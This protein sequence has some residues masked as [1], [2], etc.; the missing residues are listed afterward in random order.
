M[1]RNGHPDLK[2]SIPMPEIAARRAPQMDAGMRPIAEATK[3]ITLRAAIERI[4]RKAEI[5]AR[6]GGQN[7]QAAE[8][9]RLLAGIALKCIEPVTATGIATT[10][11]VTE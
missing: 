10:E 6:D 3:Q 9:I 8:E 1:N 5:M 4:S 11:S 7:R 2:H